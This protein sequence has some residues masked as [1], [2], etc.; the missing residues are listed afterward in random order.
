ML[1]F[2]LASEL[3]SFNHDTALDPKPVDHSFPNCV[4]L[5]HL[6]AMKT[7]ETH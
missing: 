4:L 3:Y 7:Y 6:M 1:K 5:A 2:L